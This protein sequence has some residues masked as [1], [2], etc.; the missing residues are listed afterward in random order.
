MLYAR[1]SLTRTFIKTFAR[2]LYLKLTKFTRRSSGPKSFWRKVVSGCG[3]VR[4]MSRYNRD[5]IRRSRL[6][7]VRLANEEVREVWVYGEK[8]IKEV[9]YDWTFEI[10]IK[11][12]MICDYS[13]NRE[14]GLE[15]C[16]AS[17]DKIII[18]SLVNIEERSRRIRELG[19]KDDRI[20]FLN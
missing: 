14:D 6:C 8:D 10:P 17:R 13:D 18:A 9:L 5:V 3:F 15:V 4:D 2:Q 16:A 20:I 7:L 12:K 1:I 19:V 11:V